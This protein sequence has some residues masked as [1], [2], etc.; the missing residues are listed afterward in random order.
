[1]TLGGPF[2]SE[3]LVAAEESPPKT[4]RLAVETKPSGWRGL[5]CQRFRCRSK[6]GVVWHRRDFE[7]L[8]RTKWGGRI[9]TVEHS[10]ESG[11]DEERKPL[12]YLTAGLILCAVLLQGCF[13]PRGYLFFGA[14]FAALFAVFGRGARFGA[15]HLGLIGLGAIYGVSA[16]VNASGSGDVDHALLPCACLAFALL[17]ACLSPRERQHLL[18]A[19][20]AAGCVYAVCAL[21]VL[22]GA[23]PVWGAVVAGRLQLGFQYANAA[24]IWLAAISLATMRMEGRP[25]VTLRPSAVVALLLTKSLGAIGLFLLAELVLA[26]RDT[27]SDGWKGE[28]LLVGIALLGALGISAVPWMPAKLVVI[29]LVIVVGWYWGDLAG[30]CQKL[31]LYLGTPVLLLVGLGALI[32]TGRIQQGMGTLAERFSQMRDAVAII[33]SYPILGA[34]PNAWEGIYQSFQTSDYVSTVVHSSYLQV[35][36]STGLVGLVVMTI[37]VVWSVRRIGDVGSPRAAAYLVILVHG[38]LDFSLLFLSVDVLAIL[39]LFSAEGESAAAH[40]TMIGTATRALLGTVLCVI[41]LGGFLHV[42]MG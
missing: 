21:V 31:R 33:A 35:G 6:A 34:G 15:I 42:I 25:I 11:V 5:Y 36:V 38:L 16:L 40:D 7:I 17:A 28:L 14:I 20:G 2:A 29:A 22:T 37:L 9:E 27:S 13:F 26:L 10:Q 19:T 41:C 32:A 1:M 3:T 4:E 18:Q 39:L 30:R 23:V 12:I 24:G 8:G